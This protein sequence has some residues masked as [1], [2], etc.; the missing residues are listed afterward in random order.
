MHNESMYAL[1]L[2]A[3]ILNGALMR[4][5]RSDLDRRLQPHGIGGW[6][7]HASL[8][9]LAEHEMTSREL[10]RKLR[11]EPATV[12]PVIDALERDGLVRRGHD[13]ADRRRTPLTLTVH[14][15]AVLRDTPAVHADDLLLHAF[16]G[17]GERKSRQYIELLRELMRRASNDDDMVAEVTAMAGRHIARER[18]MRRVAKAAKATSE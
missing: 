3:R 8:A 10:S 16:V 2:E 9:L 5:V 18:K 12:V 15:Q 6:L 7:Q 14:G 11:V 4:L 13:P 17:M 1:T